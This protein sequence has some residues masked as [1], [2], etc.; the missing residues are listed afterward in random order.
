MEISLG[1][2]KKKKRRKKM[3]LATEQQSR[4]RESLFQDHVEA[5]GSRNRQRYLSASHER[6]EEIRLQSK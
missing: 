5:R 3:R 2:K 6:F 4:R 1:P